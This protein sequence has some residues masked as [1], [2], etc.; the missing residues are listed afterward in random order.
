[1]SYTSTFFAY[2]GL[3]FVCASASVDLETDRKIQETIHTQFQDR[4]LLCIARELSCPASQQGITRCS[5]DRLRTIVSYDRILVM[6]HGSVAVSTD[7]VMP[8][9]LDA[10]RKK[11]CC[12]QEFDT[13]IALFRRESS[14]FRSLCQESGIVLTDIEECARD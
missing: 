3:I 10:D 4:T 7:L 5:L 6:D 8:G 9:L 2:T 14:I 12:H 11:I 1:M 13:P